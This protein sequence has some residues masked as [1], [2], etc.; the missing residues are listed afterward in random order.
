MRTNGGRERRTLENTLI[1]VFFQQSIPPPPPPLTTHLW[2]FRGE[3]NYFE[4]LVKTRSSKSSTIA[5]G[6]MRVSQTRAFVYFL[7]SS[8]N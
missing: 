7:A 3:I 1:T 8:H 5:L 4:G 6:K 2:L